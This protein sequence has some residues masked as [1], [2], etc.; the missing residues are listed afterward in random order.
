ML[1]DPRVERLSAMS[2]PILTQEADKLASLEFTL[3]PGHP[4][5]DA[6]Q[7]RGTVLRVLEDG[8]LLLPVRVV[9][10]K[11]TFKGGIEYKCEDIFG[12]L[13]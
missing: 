7:I 3:Y 2:S 1:F 9:S 4:L 12:H 11:R 10:R 5:Y 6:L 13:I 8:N